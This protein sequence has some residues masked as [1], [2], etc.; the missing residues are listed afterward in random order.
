MSYLPPDHPPP[1]Y[2]APSS[3]QPPDHPPPS[4]AA[5]SRQPP[6]HHEKNQRWESSHPEDTLES[7][8]PMTAEQ[9]AQ[10]E[11]AENAY[12]EE[13][14]RTI[15]RP[16]HQSS[17]YPRLPKVIAIP[18]IAIGLKIRPPNPMMRA[19]AQ[20][21]SAYE[22]SPKDFMQMIDTINI[23][24]SPSPPF[25][26]M[27]LASMGVGFVPHHW[28]QGV[29]AGLGVLAGAGIAGTCYLRM[30]RCLVKM[31]EEIWKPRGLRCR[32]LKDRELL[33]VL[34][35]SEEQAANMMPSLDGGPLDLGPQ[36]DVV[37]RRLEALSPYIAPLDFNVPAPA[38]RRN[39]L[40]NMSAKQQARKISKKERKNE[41]EVLKR[42]KSIE[43]TARKYDRTSEELYALDADWDSDVSSVLSMEDE[44][45]K[46]DN[47]HAKK[48]RKAR[49]KMT[50]ASSEK[51]MREREKKAMEERKEY[52]KERAKIQKK[53]D[54]RMN[55]G[56]KKEKRMGKK[57]NK[58]RKKVGS[59]RWIVIQNW[60]W[61]A[62]DSNESS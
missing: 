58:E 43:K 9:Q 27:Q 46:L 30:K 62:E 56:S 7:H 11:A 14:L 25:Q 50:S 23:C 28:A 32:L 39:P 42:R 29:S 47:K 26:V 36:T 4:Y 33:E 37:K 34:G 16:L 40:D 59:L 2:A 60:D 57:E 55:K 8:H 3:Y 41:K 44:L 20:S 18:Q 6:Q 21:L 51:K 5:P 52:E 19:Y 1:S 35:I 15:P 54:K 10:E 38:E 13:S 49:E 22:I 48:E 61:E 45:E 17:S 12:L 31:R 53:L 24:L